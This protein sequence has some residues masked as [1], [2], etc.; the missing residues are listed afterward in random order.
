M[1]ASSNTKESSVRELHAEFPPEAVPSRVD[2][3]EIK[4][5]P[6]CFLLQ[7]SEG[8]NVLKLNETSVLIWE[9]CN[10]ELS[11]GDMLELLSESFPE[12]KD[13]LE[14]DVFR[15]LDEFQEEEVITV[16]NIG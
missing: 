8:K 13:N 5:I 3:Y 9:L 12:A 10:G 14:K 16:S 1:A 11:V 4:K 2:G 7:D 15:V 6:C